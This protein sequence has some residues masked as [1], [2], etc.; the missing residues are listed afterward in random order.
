MK[1]YS[2]WDKLPFGGMNIRRPKMSKRGTSSHVF[3]NS[4]NSKLFCNFCNLKRKK[5]E[6]K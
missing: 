3:I 4:T 1:R 5:R 2:F 6:M